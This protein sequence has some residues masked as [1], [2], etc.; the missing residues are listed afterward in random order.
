MVIAHKTAA[1]PQKRA[2][3]G[4]LHNADIAQLFDR[5]ALLLEMQNANPFR[6]RAYQNAART[7]ENLPR[8]IS[9][10]LGEGADLAE[11]PGIG[12]DLAQKIADIAAKGVF[13]PLEQIKKH[14]PAGLTDLA[15]VPGLGPKRI[16]LLYR[17]LKIA[18]IRELAAAARAGRLRRL[19]GFGP[20]IEQSILKA[21]EQHRAA[22]RLRLSAA[23]QIATPLLEYLK[24]LA[25][26]DQAVVAG[27][28]RRRKDTVGD[29]DVLVTCGKGDVIA[30][31]IDYPEVAEILAKG[32]TR[33]TVKLKSGVQVD[34]RV[35]A[36]RSY[37][38]ALVYFTGSKA[39][40]IALRK[41]AMKHGLKFNEYGVFKKERWLAG[42][43]ESDV[44]A[45]AGLAYIEPELRENEGE[46]EAAAAGRLP[47]L[48][49]LADIKGDLHSHTSASDGEATIEEMADAARQRGYRYLAISDHT[50]HV[51]IVHG[52]DVSRLKKQMAAIDRLN[53]RYRNFKLLKSAEVDILAD[54]KLGIDEG[55]LAELDFVVASIHTQFN[56]G[57]QEQTERLIRAMD[58]RAVNIIGHPTGRLLGERQ[59]YELDIR[60]LAL[61]AV[62]RRCYLEINAQP[63]R[64]DLSDV[65]SR[66]AK[67]LGARFAISTDAHTVDTLAYMRF[68]VDQARRGWLEAKDVINTL[69]TASLLKQFDR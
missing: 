46:L 60:R 19:S 39:H 68:G 16:K 59:G 24:S 8:D 14:L 56:L 6:V 27:S 23:E 28:F 41:M 63:S 18:S 29:L 5:Y 44:Y 35:V 64:L 67:S 38:A 65:H 45:R 12:K 22:K 34:L 55:I 1:V 26:V 69:D 52:Q 51:G 42:T 3:T 17:K 53:A 25:D 31:F 40:N 13:A 2:F 11:L 10:M 15:D 9:Q 37:G 58:H 61:A 62:E 66:L 21:A 4:R 47:A 49:T 48:V 20:K 33:A 36:K 50:K 32:T 43:T 54:G 30:H 57:P 7:I